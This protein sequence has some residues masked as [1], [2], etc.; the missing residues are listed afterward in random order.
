L[1]QG[2]TFPLLDSNS[3]VV[4]SVTEPAGTTVKLVNIQGD[5]L[6][7]EYNG[8]A[9]KVSWKQTDLAEEVAKSGPLAPPAPAATGAPAAT[10]PPPPAA[11]PGSDAGTPARN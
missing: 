7:L 1:R 8:M 6:T 5:Q 11:A 2:L 3:Q 9:Q 10:P 4:G